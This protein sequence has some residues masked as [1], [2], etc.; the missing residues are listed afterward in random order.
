MKDSGLSRAWARSGGFAL[1][2]L[3]APGM[4]QAQGT[5]VYVVPQQPIYYAPVGDQTTDIDLN[6][7][8]TVDY[9]LVSQSGLT[10]LQPHG[11]NSL[12]VVP[13]L[14]P[15][16]GNF[17]APLNQGDV[18][19]ASPSSLNPVF[20]WYDSRTDPTGQSLVAGLSTAG[21]LG[22]FFNGIH[23]AGLRFQYGGADHYGWM[24]I[25]SFSASVPDGQILGWAYQTAPDSP[26]Y[27][28]EGAVPE[29]SSLALLCLAGFLW[30][31]RAGARWWGRKSVRG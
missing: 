11:N 8:G 23:Y 3:L 6:G 1:L 28:G 13:E 26:L 9:S 2:L 14:P 27:A 16:V 20:V 4:V 29:P 12:I 5:I 31:L 24:E 18:I 19:N 30:S 10:V 22:Y 21:P 7:D 17:L 15:D 25:N